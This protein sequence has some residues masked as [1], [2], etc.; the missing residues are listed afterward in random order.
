MQHIIVLGFIGVDFVTGSIMAI[1]AGDFTSTKMREGLYRKFGS[2][3]IIVMSLLINY[4]Q[5]YFS[6]GINVDVNLAVESYIIL[7]EITSIIENVGKINPN[8][9]PEK[10]K[11]ILGKFEDRKK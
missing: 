4:A 1:K 10:I 9:L 2:I 5:R 6:L 8:I 3:L 11:K 7:M